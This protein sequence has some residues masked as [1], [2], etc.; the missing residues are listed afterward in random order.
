LTLE[1]A[2]AC[3]HSA[4]SGASVEWESHDEEEEEF[5]DDLI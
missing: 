5:D 1:I 2:E 4:S 3:Y